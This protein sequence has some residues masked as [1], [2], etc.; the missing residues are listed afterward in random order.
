MDKD[1][2][3]RL[4]Q[5]YSQEK[6]PEID[7]ILSMLRTRV[8]GGLEI[9]H[10]SSEAAPYWTKVN[11]GL[12]GILEDPNDAFQ[13]ALDTLQIKPFENDPQKYQKWLLGNALIIL[14]DPRVRPMLVKELSRENSVIA[15]S[16]SGF[17][18]YVVPE[19]LRGPDDISDFP[20]GFNLV[21]S[22]RTLMSLQGENIPNASELVQRGTEKLKDEGA[23]RTID[24]LYQIPDDVPFVEPL[25]KAIHS[26]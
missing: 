12:E 13:F 26:S 17:L 21:M 19:S 3:E 8:S 9:L 24:A 4:A 1:K 25:Y 16:L 7:K 14:N 15:K 10:K 2:V 23:K 22:I 11:Q 18:D 20:E 6:K 5:V